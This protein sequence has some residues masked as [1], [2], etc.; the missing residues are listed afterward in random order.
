MLGSSAALAIAY[1]QYARLSPQR[2]GN[3][4]EEPAG[5]SVS[6][7]RREVRAVPGRGS[8]SKWTGNLTTNPHERGVPDKVIQAILRHEDAAELHQDGAHCRGGGDEAPGRENCMFS[9]CAAGLN[10]LIRKLLKEW[11]RRSDLNR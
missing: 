8:T 11:S 10:R 5:K 6:T 4:N 2:K 7:S 3:P 9:R 1:G